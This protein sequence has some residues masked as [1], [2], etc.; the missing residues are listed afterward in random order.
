AKFHKIT[1]AKEMWEAI[2][3]RFGRNDE[4]IK[5]Q[6]YILKQQFEGFSISKSEGLHK[7]YNRF[8]SLLSQPKIHG[9]GVSTKD[10]NQKFL[11]VFKSD[12][13]GSTASSSCTQ[14]VAFVSF[15]SSNNTNEV[16][17]TYNVSTSS[18]HNSQKEGVDWT[19]HAEDDTKNYALMAFYSSN[20]SLDTE[21]RHLESV[22]KPVESKHKAVSESKVWSDAPIVKE[23]ESDSDDEYVFKA[24]VKQEKASC[25]FT[26]TVKHVKTHRQTIKDQDTCSQ[27]PKVPKRDWTDFM[28]KRLGLGYGYV[29]PKILDLLP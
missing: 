6:K 10:S 28:S 18:G 14:N 24:S 5:M 19:G 22:P 27:N 8:H 4:S 11:R 23:Y 26:N 21:C 17:T 1:D 25:A 2:K 13:K 7:G 20:S 9:A 29:V 15:D 12:V 3:S 16:S